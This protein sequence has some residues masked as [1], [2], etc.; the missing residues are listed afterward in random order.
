[1]EDIPPSGVAERLKALPK[2]TAYTPVDSSTMGPGTAELL[3]MPPNLKRALLMR[4][5]RPSLP[6]RPGREAVTWWGVQAPL[7]AHACG[8]VCETAIVLEGRGLGWCGQ[9]DCQLDERDLYPVAAVAF[10]QGPPVAEL[11][12]RGIDEAAGFSVLVRYGKAGPRGTHYVVTHCSPFAVSYGYC[13]TGE[14]R[15]LF[16]DAEGVDSFPRWAW[17]HPEESERVAMVTATLLLREL[18]RHIQ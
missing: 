14:I 15:A 18:A 8:I 9:P 16:A 1:M 7:L 4:S 3:M 12:N 5:E 2:I 10:Y 11:R 17:T 6:Q 13:N